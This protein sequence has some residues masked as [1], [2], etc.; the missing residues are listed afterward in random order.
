MKSTLFGLLVIAYFLFPFNAKDK[1]KSQTISGKQYIVL[2]NEPKPIA[3]NTIFYK[4]CHQEKEC[5]D[6]E[7]AHSVVLKK[8]NGNIL[9]KS[10][11]ADTLKKMQKPS[12]VLR[13]NT[14]FNGDYSFQ[15]PTAKCLI[16]SYAKTS[17]A[18]PV[19][20]KVVKSNSKFDLTNST[21][22]NRGT[23]ANST[24]SPAHLTANLDR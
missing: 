11:L 3:D 9:A 2:A 14:D 6:F 23:V 13:I 22:I 19:W 12:K 17:L 21:M 20:L 18:N 24:P 16:Y 5:K 4:P 7:K 8:S 15:C 10:L 1:S